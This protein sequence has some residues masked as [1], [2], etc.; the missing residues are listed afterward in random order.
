MIRDD[1]RKPLARYGAIRARSLAA[2]S[3]ELH[4]HRGPDPNN[5]FDVLDRTDPFDL[6]AGML[7]AIKAAS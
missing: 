6:F 1:H 7:Y 5:G 4:H 2:C 3:V